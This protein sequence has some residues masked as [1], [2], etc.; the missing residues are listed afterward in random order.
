MIIISYFREDDK[1]T[2]LSLLESHSNYAVISP[3]GDHNNQIWDVQNGIDAGRRCVLQTETV[4]HVGQPY[5][6]V[7]RILLS[8]LMSFVSS[9]CKYD[10][11]N[12]DVMSRLL[13]FLFFVCLFIYIFMD[14]FIIIFFR[15]FTTN[16][17]L[18]FTVYV[19]KVQNVISAMFFLQYAAQYPLQLSPHTLILLI[20]LTVCLFFSLTVTHTTL[21]SLVH[22]FLSFLYKNAH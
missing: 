10:G 11:I 18:P 1:I 15:F 20:S 6:C 14:V 12:Y 21:Q 22:P 9:G 7:W 5:V 16:G 13:F 2:L 4:Q 17:I 3:T 19:A 8:F